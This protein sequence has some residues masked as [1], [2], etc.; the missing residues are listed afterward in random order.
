MRY[1]DFPRPRF[2]NFKSSAHSA[3]GCY[4]GCLFNLI[5]AEGEKKKK[6]QQLK[7]HILMLTAGNL[8]RV[9]LPI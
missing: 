5:L 2:W 1:E 8:V 4:T 6:A 3:E 9:M 7:A